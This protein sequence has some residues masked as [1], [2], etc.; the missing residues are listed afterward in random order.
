[1]IQVAII[2]GIMKKIIPF[3]TFLILQIFN[4]D[5]CEAQDQQKID[6]L[7][8]LLNKHERRDTIRIKLLLGLGK[9]IQ[10]TDPEKNKSLTDE[11]LHISDSLRYEYGTAFGFLRLGFYHSIKGDDSLA[12]NEYKKSLAIAE[13]IKNYY[14]I[15][16]VFSN[17]GTYYFKSGKTDSALFYFNNSISALEK[18]GNKEFL[19]LVLSNTG[20]IYMHQGDYQKALEYFLRAQ[21]NLE[22]SNSKSNLSNIY[23]NLSDFYQE[24]MK[25]SVAAK[26][27]ALKALKVSEESGSK[28]GI[29]SGYERL[30]ELEK[31]PFTARL[32]FRKSLWEYEKIDD[33]DGMVR[34]MNNIGTSFLYSPPGNNYDSAIIYFQKS[35]VASAGDQ[36]E[37]AEAHQK[38]GLA[39]EKKGTNEAAIKHYLTALEIAVKEQSNRMIIDIKS[40]LSSANASLGNYKKAYQYY[41]S[42][43]TLKD[44]ILDEEKVKSLNEVSAKYESEKKEKEIAILNKDK[45]IQNAEIKRQRL[46]K[47]SFIAGFVLLLLLSVLLYNYYRTKHLLKL[48][49]LRNNIA[50]DLHDDVGSTLSSIAIFSELAKQ[51]SKEVIPML[52][53]IS[54]SSRKMLES[55]ADI[56]WTI[57][58]GNDNFEKIILRMRSFAYELLGAKKIDFE[59]TADDT[60]TKIKLPMDIRKNLY[61]IFKEAINNLVKYADANRALFSIKGTKNNLEMLIR[62]N[63]KGFDINKSSDGNGLRNMKKRAEEIGATLFIESGAGMGTTIQFILKTS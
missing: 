54:E 22:E 4:A 41:S 26:E 57:N 56:V 38:L 27:Y 45:E 48:Q 44:S 23:F 36:T 32:F 10:M 5:L 7:Q 8:N 35:L 42:F 31:N 43:S 9:I 3:A 60:V 11:V 53:S 2:P 50:S 39:L 62:D 21:R 52:E 16:N 63:G 29:A 18:S 58:P 25:N 24:V 19:G 37:L 14:L 55:M 34:E 51:Q 12:S 46:I 6:S 47:N 20:A 1:M 40:G 33:K 30:G 59:F 13:K 61:L 15:G 28:I 49:T 17:M